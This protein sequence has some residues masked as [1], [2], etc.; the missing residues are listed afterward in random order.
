MM[1]CENSNTEKVNSRKLTPKKINVTKVYLLLM[2]LCF[3]GISK[4]QNANNIAGAV[5]DEKKQALYGVTVMLY[6][7][8]DSTLVKAI[9][10]DKEG[11]FFFE[12]AKPGNYFISF[13]ITGYK[14]HYSAKIGRAHV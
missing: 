10:T 3:Y 14:K 7:S 4:A 6:K 11:N 9:F 1:K 8:G 13:T 2:L 5:M 12:K